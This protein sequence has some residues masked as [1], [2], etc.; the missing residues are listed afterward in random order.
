MS[1]IYAQERHEAARPL[2]LC[3]LDPNKRGLERWLGPLEARVMIEIW[4]ADAPRTVKRIWID[5]QRNGGTWKYTTIMTTMTRL[6]EK[7]MLNRKRTGL[8]FT[9]TVR[10]TRSRFEERQI[11]AALVSLEAE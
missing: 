4:E 11:A 10:E 5:L 9:Y 1:A 8:S 7:G 2:P 3:K 6:W